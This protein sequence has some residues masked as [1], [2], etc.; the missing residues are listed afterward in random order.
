MRFFDQKEAKLSKARDFLNIM[1]IFAKKK[2]ADF[3]KSL[4]K[5]NGL[6]FLSFLPSLFS[7]EAHTPQLP[8]LGPTQQH[9][10]KGR[11][12][13]CAVRDD[14]DCCANGSSNT[15]TSQDFKEKIHLGSFTAIVSSTASTSNGLQGPFGRV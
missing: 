7:L 2:S 4:R 5:V 11:R 6:A 8:K 10:R 1:Q 13:S 3:A 15:K 14:D 12:R 9:A